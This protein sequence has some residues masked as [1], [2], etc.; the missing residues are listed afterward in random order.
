MAI[1]YKTDTMKT[2]Y[3]EGSMSKSY[4]KQKYWVLGACAGVLVLAG[5][6]CAILL[7]G[8]GSSLAQTLPESTLPPPT[9]AAATSLTQSSI[10]V[11]TP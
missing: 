7:S 5:G 9:Q 8:N 4:G 6:L 3:K 2:C 1:P 11:G 10:V